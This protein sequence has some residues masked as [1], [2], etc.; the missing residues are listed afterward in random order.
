MAEAEHVN[1]NAEQYIEPP[2]FNAVIALD[3][4]GRPLVRPIATM[5]TSINILG[6]P[7]LAY[8][9]RCRKL[10]NFNAHTLQQSKESFKGRS[11]VQGRRALRFLFMQTILHLRHTLLGSLSA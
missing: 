7:A 5:S 11:R 9:V 8:S 10:S 1:Q 6:F 2:G 4:L 3:S